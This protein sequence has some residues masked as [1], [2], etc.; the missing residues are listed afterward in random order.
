MTQFGLHSTWFV[1]FVSVR[2]GLEGCFISPQRAASYKW[3]VVAYGDTR[4]THQV[5]MTLQF[6]FP[7]WLKQCRIDRDL[8]QAQLA[9]RA[10][11]SLSLLRKYESGARTPPRATAGRLADALGL[12][13]EEH[14]VFLH[15]A[16]PAAV[17]TTVAA[18]TPAPPPVAPGWLPAAPTPLIGRADDLARLVPLILHTPG[19]L[20]TLVGPPGVGKSRL[21]LA[22]VEA[23]QAHF[24]DGAYFLELAAL[25]D[26]ADVA[27][28][29]AARF[30]VQGED[31]EAAIANFVGSRALVLA[32]DNFEHLLAAAPLVARL[33]RAGPR[34]VILATSRVP[35]RLRAETR[36]FVEP[37]ALPRTVGL[38][39]AAVAPA[40]R[41]FC[42]RA[43]AVAPSFT[44]TA[45]NVAHVVSLCQRLDG[46]P[47]AIELAAARSDE[48]EPE[49][50]L[51]SL[52][53]GLSALDGGFADLPAHQRTIHTTIA[54]SERLLPASA[55]DSFLRLGV[56]RGTFDMTAAAA[57]GAQHLDVLVTAG[58]LQA[59]GDGRFQLLETLR[60]YAAERLAS[61]P[62][63]ADI[64]AR[65]AAHYAALAETA[66]PLLAGATAPATLAHLDA[67]LPNLRAA[68]GW[69]REGDGGVAAA[70]I[71]AA[72][73][74]YW[75][76]R[77]AVREGRL[78][79]PLLVS[80]AVHAIPPALLARTLLTVGYL[81]SQQG[82]YNAM[83]QIER[84]L[85]LAREHST[86]EDVAL[87]LTLKGMLSRFPGNLARCVTILT[88]ASAAA[89]KARSPLL[90]A[91]AINQLG[92]AY[93]IHGRYREA[94]PLLEEAV[95]LARQAQ[96]QVMMHRYRCDL[97]EALRAM[98]DLG[99]AQ[100]VLVTLLNEL[101]A[102]G[103]ST[104]RWEA[105][106]RLATIDLEEGQLDAAGQR[107]GEVTRIVQKM[108]ISYGRV[109]VLRWQGYVAL[110]RGDRAG[111][112]AT[113]TVAYERIIELY[114]I[115][116]LAAI[117]VGLAHVWLTSDPARA[118]RLCGASEGIVARFALRE[119]RQAERL[120]RAVRGELRDAEHEFADTA[121]HIVVDRIP[122]VSFPTALA[123][124][125]T[126][127]LDQVVAAALRA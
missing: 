86:L 58:L 127:R 87:G 109:L 79:E 72:L 49:A 69:S 36:F 8:T 92:C 54:W 7:S 59:N 90:L 82:E 25:D 35:L 98:G 18:S 68:I 21:A 96:E 45:A 73:R 47:L 57:V 34:L 121:A 13:G 122:E 81:A 15:M 67:E 102:D 88:E 63:A 93:C 110:A 16:R 107:L 42:E 95:T 84:G 39:A 76:S 1:S 65:Y 2:S 80:N 123:A 75:L 103:D 116:E 37:L 66:G 17:P 33:L 11:I 43:G 9:T 31:R 38:V 52:D 124:R 99:E 61:A 106:L 105:L 41:L 55:R 112:R 53:V 89:R 83:E 40:T 12:V 6:P 5:R 114:G 97:A 70:R 94:L 118:A 30:G 62:D 74:V 27:A 126:V 3:D 113:L 32:L 20:V 117:L 50:L 91:Y 24:S 10:G 26:S 19:R 29:L 104:A 46:L 22:A 51:A 111:A 119:D 78:V 28:L 77:G 85:A 4:V 44:L 101:G 71:T 125:D 60:A 120:R 14:T 48:L 64:H 56:F 108:G 23:L 115:E 100:R